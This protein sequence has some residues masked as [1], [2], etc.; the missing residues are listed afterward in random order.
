MVIWVT[1]GRE[2]TP[3]NEILGAPSEPPPGAYYVVNTRSIHSV[4]V[5][6]CVS[7]NGTPDCTRYNQVAR[8]VAKTIAFASANELALTSL[9]PALSA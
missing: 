1:P 4:T 7:F 9:A 6:M 3:G 8:A 5:Y 2:D